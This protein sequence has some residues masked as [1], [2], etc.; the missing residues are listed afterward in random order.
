MTINFCACLPCLGP[1]VAGG[2]ATLTWN[3]SQL[4]CSKCF[5]W[6]HWVV[7]LTPESRSTKDLFPKEL[8]FHEALSARMWILTDPKFHNCISW[9]HPSSDVFSTVFDWIDRHCLTMN[10]YWCSKQSNGVRSQSLLSLRS[11][12]FLY[13]FQKEVEA[14]R[15]DKTP[16]LD[17]WSLRSNGPL[18]PNFNQQ[19][20]K[21]MG[22]HLFLLGLLYPNFSGL[23]RRC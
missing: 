17:K 11:K 23:K 13:L 12:G 21:W 10:E 5:Y 8:K 18:G 15:I 14:R 16:G 1:E 7:W 19:S 2:E 6:N 9:N 20:N 3:S 4:N 22:F